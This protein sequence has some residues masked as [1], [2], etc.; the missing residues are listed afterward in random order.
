MTLACNRTGTNTGKRG[1]HR[2]RSTPHR[3]LTDTTIRQ[4]RGN[5]RSVGS[6]SFQQFSQFSLT[7]LVT[8]ASAVCVAAFDYLTIRLT[9]LDYVITWI[10]WITCTTWKEGRKE[11]WRKNIM[12]YPGKEE[13]EAAATGE[14]EDL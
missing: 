14:E 13:N 5:C 12:C 10:T 4:G 3:P 1:R 2:H 6:V 9:C 11:E 8:L 7:V